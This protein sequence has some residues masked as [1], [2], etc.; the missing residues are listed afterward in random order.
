M[1]PEVS[2]LP[3]AM[4]KALLPVH[5]LH[6]YLLI[7]ATIHGQDVNGTLVQIQIAL[8]GISSWQARRGLGKPTPVRRPFIFFDRGQLQHSMKSIR[9]IPRNQFAL[10]LTA[11]PGGTAGGGMVMV[12]GRSR[13]SSRCRGHRAKSRTETLQ[14]GGSVRPGFRMFPWSQDSAA[15]R[16]VRPAWR[17]GWFRRVRTAGR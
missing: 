9:I 3:P 8:K 15:F 6:F 2:G 1:D 11:V 14:R 4:Q 5:C 17:S 7:F 16:G 13:G 12:S 10:A